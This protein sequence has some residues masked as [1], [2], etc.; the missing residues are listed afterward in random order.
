MEMPRIAIERSAKWV[1][2]QT[3]PGLHAV[4]GVSGLCLKVESPASRSWVLRATMPNGDRRSM[5]LGPFPLVGLA[6]ARDAARKARLMMMAKVDPIDAAKA[7]RSALRATEAKVMTFREA[8]E[9]YIDSREHTWRN[10]RSATVWR[11]SL[12]MHAYGVI[13][14]LACGDVDKAHILSI[15]RPIWTND[16]DGRLV[17]AMRLRG[18]IEKILDYARESGWRPELP[19]PA[20]WKGRLDMVLPDPSQLRK[21]KPVKHHDAVKVS[22]IGAFMRDLRAMEGVTVRC[23]EFTTLNA[24]RS[25]EARGAMWLEFDLDAKQPTWTI[26][27]KRMKT[28]KDHIVPLSRQSVELLKA[29]PRFA[30]NDLVFPSPQSQTVLSDMAMLEVMRRMKAG[31]VPHGMRSTFRVWA[32]ERTNYPREIA[33]TALAHTVGEN[34]VERAYLRTSFFDKRARL[35]QDWADFLDRVEDATGTGNVVPLR[36]AA[37]E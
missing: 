37:A 15:L 17:T 36:L 7:E 14:D 3:K 23:L 25:G 33:E 30:H 29:Q 6:A 8:A 31:G 21:V 26:P 1:E 2:K 16:D 5:G 12:E 24:S 27:G 18:R 32:A 19:N 34:S 20:V 35:M 13:G 11:S 4:G 9:T 22:D 10:D 28:G